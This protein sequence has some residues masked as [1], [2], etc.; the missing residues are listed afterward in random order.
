M[1]ADGL[2][3]TGAHFFYLNIS[4]SQKLNFV[5][6]YFQQKASNEICFFFS[7]GFL[8]GSGVVL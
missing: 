6:N 1:Q 8:R 4:E 2:G 5:W 3:F 7:F